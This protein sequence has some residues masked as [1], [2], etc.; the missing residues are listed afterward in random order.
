MVVYDAPGTTRDSIFIPMER[1]GQQYI[2]IDTAGVR[3]KAKVTEKLEKFSIIKTLQAIA[4]SNVVILL[5]DATAGI[6][7]QDLNLMDFIV[8]SG[9]CLVIA[10]NKWDGLATEQKEKIYDDL[11]RRLHFV[12][13]AE[14]HYISALHGSGVGNLFA[15]VLQAYKSAVLDLPTPKLTALLKRF[16][17]K[18]EPP[19]APGG[20][21]IKL[22]YA[23]AGGKNPPRIVIHGNQ[24][25]KLPGSYKRYLSKSFQKELNLVG[26]PVLMEFRTGGN[27]YA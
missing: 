13:F 25:D 19:V 17:A 24:T 7:D 6:V 22:R 1:D 10:I 12:S 14:K 21:R 20:R 8:E 4:A 9:R 11:R 2:L 23:H 18:H 3:R 16:V 26:T 27:P 5:L 15:A